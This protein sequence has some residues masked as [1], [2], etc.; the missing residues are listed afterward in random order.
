MHVAGSLFNT[1]L[2]LRAAV[3]EITRNTETSVLYSQLILEPQASVYLGRSR[4]WVYS[5]NS[6]PVFSKP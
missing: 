2:S 3:L 5:G 1:L 4:T 6:L